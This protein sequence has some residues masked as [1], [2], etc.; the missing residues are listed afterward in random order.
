MS[1]VC[2]GKKFQGVIRKICIIEKFFPN[3]NEDTAKLYSPE[4]RIGPFSYHLSI[5]DGTF[6]GEGS[7]LRNIW[8]TKIGLIYEMAAILIDSLTKIHNNKK[9]LLRIFLV[10]MNF[11]ML[12]FSIYGP[13]DYLT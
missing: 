1:I 12:S 4:A 6:F 13:Y 2:L 3:D 7:F 10:V 5:L 11:C 9:F 8:R